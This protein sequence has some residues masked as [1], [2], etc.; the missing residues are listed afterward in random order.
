MKY[1]LDTN[2]LIFSLCSPQDLSKAARSVITT[3]RELFV[4]IVSLWKIA[5][6]QCIGKLSIQSDIPRI[7]AICEGRG[8]TLIPISS[9]EIEG[10]KQLPQFHNDPFDRLIISQAMKNDYCI[11]TRDSIIPKYPVKTLW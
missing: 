8:I 3:E 5:I 11:V 6:K 4:S 10:I 7:E 1:L 2:A 9:A